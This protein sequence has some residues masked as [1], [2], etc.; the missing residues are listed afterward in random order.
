MEGLDIRL[1]VGNEMIMLS[2]EVHKRYEAVHSDQDSK[3]FAFLAAQAAS[4]MYL[5]KAMQDRN[6][7]WVWVPEFLDGCHSDALFRYEEAREDDNQDTALLMA[8]RLRL[9]TTLRR[10]ISDGRRSLLFCNEAES[11]DAVIGDNTVLRELVQLMAESIANYTRLEPQGNEVRSKMAAAEIFLAEGMLKINW[12]LQD[13]GLFT[14]WVYD[15]IYTETGRYRQARGDGDA[16]NAQAM[17]A[18]VRF[19]TT[20]AR[21]LDDPDRKAWLTLVSMQPGTKH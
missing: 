19:A 6:D 9:L 14:D 3:R 2:E 8:A 15:Y 12:D 21:R 13:W 18:R 17:L 4:C 20:L 1:R 11:W 5:M 16:A 10:R 7:D